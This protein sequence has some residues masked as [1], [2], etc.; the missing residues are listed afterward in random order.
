M[1]VRTRTTVRA[2]FK[3]RVRPRARVGW[4]SLTPAGGEVALVVLVGSRA[5]GAAEAI[6]SSEGYTVILW[7]GP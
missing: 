7:D 5:R 1:T 3:L 6:L 2:K 4:G